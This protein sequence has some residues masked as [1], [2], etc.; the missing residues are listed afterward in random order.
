[1][2]VDLLLDPVADDV[3]AVRRD[4]NTIGYIRQVG[5][6]FVA[7]RGRRLDY[8]VECGQS[9]LWDKAAMALLAE[10]DASGQ[11]SAQDGQRDRRQR[12]S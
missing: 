5:R 7:L 11:S 9:L 1:M 3:D 12:V 8:A 10:A 2:L 6:V 4:G